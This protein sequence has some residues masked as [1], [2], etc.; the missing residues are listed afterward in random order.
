MKI[1]ISKPV[2]KKLNETLSLKDKQLNNFTSNNKIIAVSNYPCP[3]PTDEVK[4]TNKN[5]KKSS[6]MDME[7]IKK[8]HKNVNSNVDYYKKLASSFNGYYDMP[9]SQ[10]DF[11]KDLL[12][13]S[14]EKSGLVLRGVN[15]AF[16]KDGVIFSENGVTLKSKEGVFLYEKTDSALNDENI[17]DILDKNGFIIDFDEDTIFFSNAKNRLPLENGTTLTKKGVCLPLTLKWLSEQGTPLEENFFNDLKTDDGYE[18]IAQL[19]IIYRLEHK[20]Y[21][22]DLAIKYFL[23]NYGDHIDRITGQVCK[24]KNFLQSLINSLDENNFYLVNL[25]EKIFNEA[26]KIGFLDENGLTFKSLQDNNEL[27]FKYLQDNHEEVKMLVIMYLIKKN[28]LTHPNISNQ[29]PDAS[30]SNKRYLGNTTDYM[31]FKNGNLEVKNSEE[32]PKHDGKHQVGFRKENDYGHSVGMYIN[33]STNTFRIFDPNIGQFS[34]NTIQDMHNMQAFLEYKYKQ[35]SNK[36]TD[37]NHF[38]FLKNQ[39]DS[40]NLKVISYV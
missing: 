18:E 29:I 5:E 21:S 6:L 36:D 34:F 16:P 12:K 4:L 39:N 28:Q 40:P 25:K 24:E 9:F 15:R 31:K 27:L 7:K 2:L 17:E 35:K 37:Q 14:L 38:D 13:S 30:F 10:N 33:N 1:I 22:T 32:L 23:K 20:S 3:V 26:T 11:L 8:D 19:N